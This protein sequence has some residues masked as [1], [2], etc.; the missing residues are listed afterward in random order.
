MQGTN[1]RNVRPLRAHEVGITRDSIFTLTFRASQSD[2]DS[3]SDTFITKITSGL[4][5]SKGEW[6]FGKE[7]QQV[8]QVPGARPFG[9]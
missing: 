5:F 1:Y 4:R 8:S 3:D 6:L 7:V 2:S 9:W